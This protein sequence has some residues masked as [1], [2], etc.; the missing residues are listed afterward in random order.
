[1]GVVAGERKGDSE[2]DNLVFNLCPVRFCF[3]T[4]LAQEVTTR[5]VGIYI[6][7]MQSND[8]GQTKEWPQLFI[9]VKRT[10]WR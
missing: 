5:T 10:L 8:G 3:T 7:G 6:V 1:M 2:R 9:K 4:R